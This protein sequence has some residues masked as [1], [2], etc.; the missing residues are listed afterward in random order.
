MIP[1]LEALNYDKIAEEFQSGANAL[2]TAVNENAWDGK[3]YIRG[4]TDDGIRFCTDKDGDAKVSLMMQAWAILGNV[5][6]ENRMHH[7]LRAI[8]DYI[9]TDIGPILYGPPFLKWRPEIG[10]E[11]VKQPGTGENGS[12][13]VHAAMM[14]AMAEIKANQPDTALRIIKQ[15]LPLRDSDCCDITRAV[16]LWMPNFWHGPHSTV[17]GRS[18]GIMSTGALA[19]FYLDICDGFFGIQPQL[20]GLQINP[21]WPSAWKQGKITRKWRNAVYHLD[22]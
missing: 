20:N 14:L 2:T 7:V 5:V 12:C 11:T 13:Y 22:Y 10:R 1:L 19:W 15:V 4:I 17:P 9:L 18:S 16:P 6:P 21:V 3:W 8:D